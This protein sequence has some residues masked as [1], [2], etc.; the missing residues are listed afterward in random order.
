M[1]CGRRTYVALMAAVAGLSLSAALPALAQNR[2]DT[3][4]HALDAN[5]Q[6]GSGGYN[7]EQTNQPIGVQYQ[8]ALVTNNVT[9]GAGFR[10]ALS[11]ASTWAWDIPTHLLSEAFWPGKGW[12]SLFLFPPASRRWR[13]QRRPAKQW[14]PRRRSITEHPTTT[15]QLVFSRCQTGRAIFRLSR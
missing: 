4:G 2:I 12:I 8:N 15:N 6:I 3:S 1:K 5:P 10:G 13:T 11:T 7:A 14:L 9:G